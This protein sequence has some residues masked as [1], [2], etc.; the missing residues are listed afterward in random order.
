MSGIAIAIRAQS[1]D[2]DRAADWSASRSIHDGQLDQQGVLYVE[3]L[4]R[5][6]S[7]VSEEAKLVALFHDAIEDERIPPEELARC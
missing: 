6:A 2:H 4:R 3:H 7:A 5:V 1:V